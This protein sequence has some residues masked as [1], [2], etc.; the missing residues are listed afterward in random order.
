MTKKYL[1]ERLKEFRKTIA[2]MQREIDY[3]KIEDI[4]R[5]TFEDL[6]CLSSELYHEY[7]EEYDPE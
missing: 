1:N 5:E 6:M 4:G 7:A 2:W 3:N